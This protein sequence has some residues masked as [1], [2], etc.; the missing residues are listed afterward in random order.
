[1]ERDTML[2]DGQVHEDDGKSWF[3]AGTWVIYRRRS[4]DN[5]GWNLKLGYRA[6]MLELGR[7]AIKLK[8]ARGVNN[9][10]SLS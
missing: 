4:A 5:F 3:L 8:S 7:Y 10:K 6:V 2:S 1:M 9:N